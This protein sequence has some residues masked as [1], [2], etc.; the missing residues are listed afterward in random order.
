MSLTLQRLAE[1]TKLS[2]DELD[3]AHVPL[4]CPNCPGDLRYTPTNTEVMLDCEKCGYNDVCFPA[5]RLKLH[6]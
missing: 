2:L 4:T 1:T 6:Q 5:E 3:A